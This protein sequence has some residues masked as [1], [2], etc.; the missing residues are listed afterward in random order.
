M[1]STI[2]TAR[3]YAYNPAVVHQPTP[4]PTPVVVIGTP[5]QYERFEEYPDPTQNTTF[6]VKEDKNSGGM[7]AIGCLGGF[8][9][10]LLCL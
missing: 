9:A 7:F 10:W 4:A 8:L 6:V 1:N 3:P 5:Y 2:P